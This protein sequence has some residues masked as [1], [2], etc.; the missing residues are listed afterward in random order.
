MFKKKKKKQTVISAY[1]EL[2]FWL[3]EIDSK[4]DKLQDV[5][6]CKFYG[7]SVAGCLKAG[8]FYVWGQRGW[9]CPGIF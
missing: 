3:D 6:G 5:G 2:T 4:I 9:G 1:L 7:N 8:N